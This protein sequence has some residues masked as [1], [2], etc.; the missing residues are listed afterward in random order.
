MPVMA[1][2]RFVHPKKHVFSLLLLRKSVPGLCYITYSVIVKTHYINSG[3]Q[4]KPHSGGTAVD[5]PLTSVTSVVVTV[6]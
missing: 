4:E 1:T 5:L 6:L 2:L 3:T